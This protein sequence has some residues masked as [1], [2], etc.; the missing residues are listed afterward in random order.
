MKAG[1]TVIPSGLGKSRWSSDSSCI[2]IRRH[3]LRCL[4]EVGCYECTSGNRNRSE[5][6]SGASSVFFDTHLAYH[7]LLRFFLSLTLTLNLQGYWPPFD[8]LASLSYTYETAH[9]LT[10][11]WDLTLTWYCACWSN[12]LYPWCLS[13]LLNRAPCSDPFCQ[14]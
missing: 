8:P 2:S 6:L 9:S 12:R 10:Y 5:L 7:D 14:S 1:N 11:W 4:L 3:R 13:S